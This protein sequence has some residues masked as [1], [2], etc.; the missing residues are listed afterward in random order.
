MVRM[1]RAGT[2]AIAAPRAVRLDELEPLRGGERASGTLEARPSSQTDRASHSGIA[3]AVHGL[4]FETPV[5][6]PRVKGSCL[7]VVLVRMARTPAPHRLAS[8]L[9]IAADPVAPV[10]AASLE[11]PVRHGRNEANWRC[12]C[13]RTEGKR[14]HNDAFTSV[15]RLGAE[16][17]TRPD[18]RVHCCGG[19]IRT[20]G[21]RVMSPSSYRCSTPRR[22]STASRERTAQRL[23]KKKAIHRVTRESGDIDRPDGGALACASRCTTRSE[24]LGPM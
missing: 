24:S 5:A 14:G 19:T 2:A 11:I 4:L 6:V 18:G 10:R 22:H 21:L 12:R 17:R 1:K 23:P 13:N 9:G 7:G 16:N 3:R 20:S 15:R 8:L